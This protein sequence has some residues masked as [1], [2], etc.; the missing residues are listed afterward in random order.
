MYLNFPKTSKTL[1]NELFYHKRYGNAKYASCDILRDTQKLGYC[2]FNRLRPTLENGH[3]KSEGMKSKSWLT[4]CE[5]TKDL[6]QSGYST[7]HNSNI[8]IS[9]SLN[10]QP[11]NYIYENNALEC[12]CR[13]KAEEVTVLLNNWLNSNTIFGSL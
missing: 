4:K 6:V 11:H 3:R 7:N 9:T 8:S 5:H 10:S 13:Y 2:K 12:D 1:E